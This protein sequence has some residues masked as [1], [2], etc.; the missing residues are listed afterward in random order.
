M[1]PDHSHHI[2]VLGPF[3]EHTRSSVLA[4]LFLQWTVSAQ[5]PVGILTW[6][7]AH[8]FLVEFFPPVSPFQGHHF[9]RGPVWMLILCPRFLKLFLQGDV[10][11]PPLSLY[12]R[13]VMLS[14]LSALLF[15]ESLSTT[16]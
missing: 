11:P 10:T 15:L 5:G 13:Q 4:S 2:S 12:L 9:P 8:I 7:V 14:D 6:T 1:F 16:M 3:L